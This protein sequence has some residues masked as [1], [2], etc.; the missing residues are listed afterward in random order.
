M[1]IPGLASTTG[2]TFR[3]PKTSSQKAGLPPGT[4]VHIGEQKAKEVQVTLVDYDQEHCEIV[5]LPR[6]DLCTLYQ[7][8]ATT[9]WVNVDGLHQADLIEKICQCFKL[10][11]LT[12][13]DILNTTQRPK[14]DIFDDY[15]FLV[16]KTQGY[17]PE[18]RFID[19]EQISLVL[20]RGFLVSFQERPGDTFEAVRN[21]IRSNRG[22]IRKM[23]MD[24]LAYSLLDTV[25]DN[26][27]TVLEQLGEEIEDLEEELIAEPTQETLRR[28]HVLKREMI[29]LR[30]SIWPL[31]EVINGLMREEETNLISETIHPFLKDLYDHTIQVIDTVETYRDILA[32]MLDIYLSSISNRMNEIMKVLTIFAAI[33]I[34]LTFITSL[35]GMNFNTE[36]SP[37]NMPELNWAFGYPFALGLM[38][39]TAA[40]MLYYFKRKKWF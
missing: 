37:W 40:A 17:N 4:P 30:K 3:I 20:G 25:I 8:K 1:N 32:G 13:E 22:R 34:P 24:Y 21:R 33:F 35:Y 26:Y 36:K 9:T 12:I 7:D 14:L 31:R 16:I 10:H 38:V 23:G 18:T 19:T 39:A 6:P 5:T 15:L 11:P 2:S 29:L 27:F 28:L